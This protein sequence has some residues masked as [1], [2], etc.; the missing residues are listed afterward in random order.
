M[1]TEPWCSWSGWFWVVGVA[2]LSKMNLEKNGKKRPLEFFFFFFLSFF[3][4]LPLRR[5]P[6][7][8]LLEKKD[9]SRFS[10]KPS[11]FTR[12]RE[13]PPPRGMGVR[14]KTFFLNLPGF[15]WLSAP[16]W[17]NVISQSGQP[18][19]DLRRHHVALQLSLNIPTI[20]AQNWNQMNQSID[21]RHVC[22]RRLS[23]GSNPCSTS[24]SSSPPSLVLPLQFYSSPPWFEPL[25]LIVLRFFPFC[26]VLLM[27]FCA[28]F[29]FW[30]RD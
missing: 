11:R 4:I 14:G 21:M 29:F 10:P 17:K 25:F 27:Y 7:L 15:Y 30:S 22:T 26:G 3:H 6:L 9:C 28:L 5:P 8:P 23:I 24:S 20:C 12:K 18:S 19:E 2:V 13:P 1:V 16:L